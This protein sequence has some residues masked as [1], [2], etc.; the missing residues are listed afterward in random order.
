M[1]RTHSPAVIEGSVG[2]NG[3]AAA[4]GQ[5][6]FTARYHHNRPGLLLLN[7]RVYLGF[8]SHCDTPPYH[9]WLFAYDAKTL[10]RVSVFNTTPTKTLR[11]PSGGG[12]D[13]QAGG[14]W[15]SGYG[16][17]S[18]AAS[19]IYLATGN[20]PFDLDR[21]GRDG[22]DSVLK[23]E[24]PSLRIAGFFAPQDQDTL[25]A[26]DLDLGSGGVM[27]LP[28]Q[29]GEVPRMMIGAGKEGTV[30]LMDRDH[31]GGFRANPPDDVLA[32]LPQAV[33][34][35][36]WGGPAYYHGASGSRIF[37]C[38]TNGSL[39]SLS[40]EGTTLRPLAQSAETF[41]YP[42][43]TPTVTSK[44][45]APRTAIVW[46]NRVVKEEIRLTAFD[47]DDV[48]HKLFESG[49]GPYAGGPKFT[50]PTV[51]DGR[52]FVG[53]DRQVAVFALPGSHRASADIS[54]L[55]PLLLGGAGM[56]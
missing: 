12:F 3:A 39:R 25:N 11:P 16:L 27:V 37:Y 1:P 45:L 41:S 50:V 6:S 29:A 49:A 51:V 31:P 40:L 9:G 17:A 8:A 47:A 18:D 48:S 10:E 44:G 54:Y 26:R 53:T 52:A 33:T 13:D 21:G 34:N 24:T 5:I 42:P 30:Y 46:A 20:G 55:D 15:Q 22:G 2:G 36:V 14:I 38:G 19:Y 32:E 56:V 23:L 43:A 35:G 4:H 7:G 28:D